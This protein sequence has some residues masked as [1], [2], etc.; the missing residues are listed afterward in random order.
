L[1]GAGSSEDTPVLPRMRRIESAA[2][3]AFIMVRL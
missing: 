3:T 1:I 2:D